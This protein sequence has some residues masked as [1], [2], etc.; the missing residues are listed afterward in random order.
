MIADEVERYLRTGES[1][2]HLAAWPGVPM[3]IPYCMTR[4]RDAMARAAP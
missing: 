4:G 1:D 2:P 3:R